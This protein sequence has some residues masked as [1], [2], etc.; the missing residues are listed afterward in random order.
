MPSEA[1]GELMPLD[2]VN[3]D[4]KDVVVWYERRRCL[5]GHTYQV[6]LWEEE[7]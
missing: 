3:F 4:G 2:G 1:Y 6:E 7:T 5:A